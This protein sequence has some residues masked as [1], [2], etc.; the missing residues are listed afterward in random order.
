MKMRGK[1]NEPLSSIRKRTVQIV[2][3]GVSVTPPAPVTKPSRTTSPTTSVEEITSIWKRPRVEDKEKDKADSRSSSV[4]DDAG[5]A[6]SRAQESFSTEELKVFSGVPSHEIVG[7]HIHKLIQVLCLCN[8]TIFFFF[9]FLCY[10]ECW[11]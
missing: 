4:F 11:I 7:R 2:E 6:M 9:L 10:P 5:L 8:F 1:K 3:K